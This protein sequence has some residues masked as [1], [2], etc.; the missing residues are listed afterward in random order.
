MA[1]EI[2][3]TWRIPDCG[4]VHYVVEIIKVKGPGQRGQVAEKCNRKNAAKSDNYLF[5]VGQ[6]RD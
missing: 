2:R 1:E 4:I 3:P 6:V 5:Q